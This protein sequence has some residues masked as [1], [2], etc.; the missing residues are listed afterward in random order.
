[1]TKKELSTVLL[2]SAREKQEEASQARQAACM[3]MYVIVSP[4]SQTSPS[5]SMQ[6]ST[7]QDHRVCGQAYETVTKKVASLS[8]HEKSSTGNGPQACLMG[9]LG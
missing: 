1:M 4:S 5:S 6:P 9:G 8:R 3:R 7:P 2:T